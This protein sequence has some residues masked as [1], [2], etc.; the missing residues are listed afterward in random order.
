MQ[1]TASRFTYKGI[2]LLPLLLLIPLVI[3]CFSDHWAYDEATT[4]VKVMD[5]SWMDIVNYN[6][7][8]LA[9]NHVLNSLYFK[10]LQQLGADNLFFFRLPSL[11]AFFFYYLYI[12]KLL[13]MKADYQLHHIDQLML[14]IWPYL[15][16]F[17]QGRGY[18]IAM[19]AFIAGLYHYKLY[20]EESKPRH[21][22]YFVLLNCLAS[23]SIFSFL[24]PF[25]AMVII[26]GIR[27]FME[28]IKSPIRILIF[29]MAI[30]V[31]FYVAVK[32]IVVSE[33]DPAVIG[34]ETLFKGGSISS[35]ISFL[36]L[37][38]FAPDKL[39]FILKA[40]ISITMVPVLFLLVK[41]TRWH[42]EITIILVSILLL[43]VS[44]YAMGALYP[45]YRGV[46]YIIMLLLL[47]FAYTNFKRNYFITAH[48]MAIILSGC[49]YLGYLF[50]FKAQKCS[51][52]AL[53][54][55]KYKT[56]MV[57]V[58]ENH[59]GTSADN[60]M[61][62]N[63]SYNVL[64]IDSDDSTT[65]ERTLDTANYLICKPEQLAWSRNRDYFEEMY[66]VASF[67]YYNKI[68]Y[69]RKGH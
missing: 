53:Q 24:Y 55:V 69:K 38:E 65:F 32:G 7:Y 60:Y 8:N 56:D 13:R 33:C 20:L 3:L 39:F 42:I 63:G 40:L 11:L 48:F 41:R 22:L 67:F 62:F 16:Y 36:A 54:D 66:P 17:A 19:T 35:I 61:Y 21:L 26:V 64:T 47:S 29:V 28:I 57:L 58:G 1:T 34:R 46:A 68:F 30:P 31:V 44:H 9:N 37:M 15:V 6:I 18:G 5:V 49:I 23:L 4:Y 59:P 14:F 12:G 52:D 27:R 51:Y 50:Y 10:W 45:V 43:V 2:S 25:A